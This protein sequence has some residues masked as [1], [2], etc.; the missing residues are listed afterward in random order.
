MRKLLADLRQRNVFRVAGVY[1]IAAWFIMQ[2]VDVLMDALELP[3][4]VDGFVLLVL[5]AG[6]LLALVFAWMFDVG[7]DGI[8]RASA[9]APAGGGR[10][11]DYLIVLSLLVL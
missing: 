11:T 7:P 10:V 4:W 8:V 1:A 9:A 5:L 6:F 2:L 3:S